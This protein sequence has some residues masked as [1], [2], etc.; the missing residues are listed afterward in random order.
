MR[1]SEHPFAA[2][3]PPPASC[4]T[5]SYHRR[6]WYYGMAVFA[7]I[8]AMQFVPLPAAPHAP[9][10]LQMRAGFWIIETALLGMVLSSQYCMARYGSS[11]WSRTL[12]VSIP[13]SLFT[14]AVGGCLALALGRA[15]NLRAPVPLTLIPWSH[16]CFVGALTGLGLCGIWSLMVVAPAVV[17]DARLRTLE[18]EKLR[19]EAEQLRAMAE[20]SRL[21]TQFEPHFLLNTLNAIAALVTQNPREARR[22]IACLGELLLDGLR[23]PDELRSLDDEVAW[24]QRYAEILESRHGERIEFCW[25][26]ADE[27]RRAQ[28]PRLLLQP[29]VENAVKHGALQRSSAGRVTV[30]TAL[31]ARDDGSQRLVCTIDDN[32]PGFSP[33]ATR[34]D[35]FGLRAVRRRLELL[36][37]EA[38]LTFEALAE[39]TRSVVDL[40]WAAVRCG[41]MRRCNAEARA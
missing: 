3:S 24:L 36:H 30:R 4:A 27:T 23:D 8:V 28:L 32:G 7:G 41:A 18:A 33:E 13:V 5:G 16:A 29:L 25:E 12:R 40:P 38:T 9:D 39:G 10:A 1:P 34:A 21:R 6:R 31:E 37:P 26:I 14:G 19:L 20:L 2:H 11:S 17:E 22:L 35:A 15:C